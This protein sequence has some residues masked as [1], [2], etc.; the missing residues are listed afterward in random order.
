MRKQ[1]LTLA[2]LGL[3][4][5]SA[6]TAE[7]YTITGGNFESITSWN[8]NASAS[9]SN[10]QFDNGEAAPSALLGGMGGVITWF[11]A[12]NF[13]A[14]GTM[15]GTYSGTITTDGAD[16][17]TGGTLTV[18]GLIGYEVRVG[19]NSWW[20]NEHTGL[21]IDFDTNMASSTYLCYETVVAPAGCAGGASTPASDIFAPLAGNEGAAGTARLAA[22][23][24][25]T[26]LTIWHEGYDG[27]SGTDSETVWT[28]TTGAASSGP[29]AD[30]TEAGDTAGV[31]SVGL[32]VTD[33]ASGAGVDVINASTGA[34]LSTIEYFD[35][36][37]ATWTPIA[38]DTVR[39]GDSDGT[40]DDPAIAML[41]QSAATGQIVVQTRL[42]SSGAKVGAGQLPFFSN[43]GW[44]PIDVAVINDVNGDLTSGDTAI[45]VLAKSTVDG[46]NEVRAKLLS[47]GSDIFLERFFSPAETATAVEAYV[48]P[49]AGDSRVSVLA[50]D[51]G[52]TAIA[53]THQVS[54]GGRLPNIFGHGS[55][56]TST[57]LGVASDGNSDGAFG[58]PALI[59]YGT[60]VSTGITIARSRDAGTGAHLK[61]RELLGAGFTP[62][63]VTTILDAS[64]NGFEDIAGSATDGGSTLNIKVRDYKSNSS[65]ADILP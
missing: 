57:D 8:S 39:D 5:S 52:G 13:T 9:V 24:D 63:A 53:E 21:V 20:F 49:G 56:I 59:F 42:V 15:T 7:D 11:D 16:N 43:T 31:G 60:R 29:R 50:T 22:T 30:V 58:D 44:T 55:E 34:A 51:A 64:G 35:T 25:G 40:S 4:V 3:G 48:A 2:V 17:V 46:R 41:A 47:D 28:L 6:A 36:A 26:T 12:T 65:V 38:I 61:T 19:S 33:V 18:T 1:I 27:I 14:P 37:S 10:L 54:N 45:A 23:F 62:D 32:M